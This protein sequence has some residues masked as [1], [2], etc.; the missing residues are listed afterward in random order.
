MRVRGTKRPET[1]D[2]VL[3]Q[4]IR[5]FH[6]LHREAKRTWAAYMAA[7]TESAGEV[8]NNADRRMGKAARKVMATPAV[9][10]P[11][12]LAKLAI[13]KLAT[14]S[15]PGAGDHDGNLAEWNEPRRPW[16][17]VVFLEVENLIS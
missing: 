8:A 1:S 17:G 15:I 4:R 13:V 3:L 7:G 16:L 11:G 12:V 14:E 9:T 10:K 5:E 2:A 6:K